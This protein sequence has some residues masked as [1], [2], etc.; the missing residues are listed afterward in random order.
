MEPPP[1]IITSQIKKRL[2][3]IAIFLFVLFILLI[4]QFFKIQIIEGPK[5]SQQADRQHFF[6]IDEPFHRGIFLSNPAV[7]KSHPE[8][9]HKF[10]TDIQ[11]F[12]LY[13]DPISIPADKKKIIADNLLK[14]P[15]NDSQSNE[16]FTE[17][18]FKR[19]RSRKLS[20]WLDS[21]IKEAILAW[22]LP[23]AKQN[24]IPRNALFF[25]ADYQRS[26]PFGKL[27]GQV[28]HTV[29]AQKDEATKQ[30]VPTGGLETYFN[31]W[32]QGKLGKRRLMRSPLHSFETGEVIAKPEN[33]AEIYLTINH[34][35]QAIAE[36]ELAKGVKRCKAKAGWA[37]M[38]NPKTGE[39]L[40]L[41]QYP[42]F[43]PSEYSKYYNDKGLLEYTKV[44]GIT[45]ANEPGSVMKP[46]TI[47][48]ALLANEQLK[49]K[50]LE[51]LFD[52]NEKMDTSNPKFPGRSKPLV[53][54]HF[55]HYLN[56]Y[57]A[58]QKSSNIYMGRIVER[59]I[60]RQG[61]E[62]YRNV[63][64]NH[65]G[66]GMKTGIELPGESRGLL[67]APGKKHPNGTLEWS[68]PTPFSLAIGHNIQAT[69]IQLVR[70]FAILANGGYM[71]KPTLVRKIVK[72]DENGKEIVLIDHTKEDWLLTRK[73]VLSK[74]I[75]AEVVKAMKYSTKPGGT[76][77]KADVWGYTEAGKSG[78]AKKIVDGNYS[79]RLYNSSFIGF[80][81]VNDPAIVLLVTMDEPE[82]G[83]IPGLGK[84]HHGGSCAAP[85]FRCIA[86]RALE[87][88]GIT[89][90]DPFGYP[91]G[92]PRYDPSKA[93]WIPEI[94]QL[95]EMYKKWNIPKQS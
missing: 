64:Q 15:I 59:I 90:D 66:F 91:V 37:I 40:A 32:L 13:V 75:V 39:V 17:Q 82:Y 62:W 35:L 83:Y 95:Q 49:K 10:V 89:P 3:L 51:E 58:L 74:A 21:E 27:L 8:K 47:A 45:D 87:Y 26:Y 70:A 68:T 36:D 81:P 34:C 71:V 29:Q 9:A 44:K 69:S 48:A 30:A 20:L 54:T 67:P 14:F 52:P 46:F 85:V 5:W 42:F 25:V 63:L 88:M 61:N 53:D 72:R 78:T 65:F 12:H 92:D 94:R 24:K 19:S 16:E 73:R 86:K 60:N 80:T 41:A 6:T 2:C 79:D 7:R 33:G 38:M 4:I 55:H 23:F 11:K 93:D 76:C 84:N 28:L 22:W 50:G 18:F 1:N 43:N 77:S 57:M 31:S 56:M